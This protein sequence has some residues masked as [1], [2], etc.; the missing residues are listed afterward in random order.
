[1]TSPRPRS[2]VLVQALLSA[3][4]LGYLGVIAFELSQ[5]YPS[6][7]GSIAGGLLSVVLFAVLGALLALRQPVNPLGWLLLSGSLVWLVNQ[8]VE[9]VLRYA[10]RDGAAPSVAVGVL[11]DLNAT[12]WP[13][14]LLLSLGVPLLLF[15][16]GRTRTR[17][18][19]WVLRV[20]VS[21]AAVTIFSNFFV[22][23][24]VDS[25]SFGGQ[26]VQNPWGVERLSAVT[27]FVSAVAPAVLLAAMAAAVFGVVGRLRTAAGV[28]RQQLRWVITGASLA[29]ASILVFPLEAWLELPTHAA[30][31]VFA[32]GLS[33]LPL[34]LAVAVLR[35]RL[36]DLDRVVS[37]TVSYAA[38]T[39][40]LVVT[41]A[42]LVT[43]VS[44]LTPSGSSL[45]VAASTLAVAALFQPVRRKV[46]SVMD[47]RFNRSRYDADLTVDAFRRRLREQV[48]LELVR[49][50][51]LMVVQDTVQ[52]QTCGLWLRHVEAAR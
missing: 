45:A 32:L 38:V 22:T 11:A 50:Q 16:D 52:P 37:R 35:Y 15:P 17:R 33:C 8:V 9:E 29:I 6:T 1:M 7:V 23:G 10:L 21:A 28:E 36:Y 40:L 20:M 48:D 27:A 46:Q 51:L 41:Y 30:D 42:G 49:D 31:V 43:A 2:R 34:S 14:G 24:D 19:S 44:R 47:R 5:G 4:L 18:A 39:G 26:P 13:L 25:S 12:M 3:T